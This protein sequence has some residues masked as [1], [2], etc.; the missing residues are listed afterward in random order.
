MFAFATFALFTGVFGTGEPS[1]MSWTVIGSVKFAPWTV[2]VA[3][4]PSGPP[5][6][7]PSWLRFVGEADVALGGSPRNEKFAMSGDGTHVRPWNV[8][9]SVPS[10]LPQ[11]GAPP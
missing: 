11:T 4:D 10:R 6:I 5:K 3:E 7:D 8:N 9:S 1:L 2:I